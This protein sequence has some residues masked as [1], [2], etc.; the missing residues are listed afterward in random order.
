MTEVNKMFC[1]CLREGKCQD[2][3][4]MRIDFPEDDNC[5]MISIRKHGELTTEQISER[6]GFN[7]RQALHK[8]ET[9]ALAKVKKKVASYKDDYI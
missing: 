8:A 5:C 9:N 1:M 3:C 6:L 7:S 4:R 2:E